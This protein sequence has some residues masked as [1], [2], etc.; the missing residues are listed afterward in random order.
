ME[1]GSAK[2]THGD[3]VNEDQAVVKLMRTRLEV[4]ADESV[5]VYRLLQPDVEFSG[6]PVYLSVVRLRGGILWAPQLDSQ[7]SESLH[8]TNVLVLEQRRVSH[9][10]D[11]LARGWD[12]FDDFK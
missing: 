11:C 2:R 4:R 5:L 6:F 7:L 9:I 12:R 3:A 8:P 10:V 1:L